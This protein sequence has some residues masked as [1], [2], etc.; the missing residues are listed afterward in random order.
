MSLPEIATG[1]TLLKD[2]I[3]LFKKIIPDSEQKEKITQKLE[4]AKR[5]FEIAEAKAA[6]DLDY[7]LCR[8]TWPPQ[9]MLFFKDE[10]YTE[11]YKCQK[12]GRIYPG[13]EPNNHNERE[14]GQTI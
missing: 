5:N 9:I 8:C 7:P 12:C 11:Q 10:K 13:D 3:P 14:W 4:E 2:I 1:I 6:K